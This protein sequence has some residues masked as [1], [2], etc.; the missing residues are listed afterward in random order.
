MLQMGLDLP[1]ELDVFGSMQEPEQQ[2]YSAEVEREAQR[3]K[4]SVDDDA[5][6]E[7]PDEAYARWLAEAWQDTHGLG[8]EGEDDDDYE[9]PLRSSSGDQ[10][11][12]HAI[13]VS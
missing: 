11:R 6:M 4:A 7:P 1:E 5:G 3:L 12:S 8:P 2:P 13:H 10:R 9:C